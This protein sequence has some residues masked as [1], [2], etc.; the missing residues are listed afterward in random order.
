M[1]PAQR[2]LHENIQW[3]RPFTRMAA[4]FSIRTEGWLPPVVRNL[5]LKIIKH[6]IAGYQRKIDG[7]CGKG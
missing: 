2:Q 7:G 1:T 3:L 5:P 6:T 4:S